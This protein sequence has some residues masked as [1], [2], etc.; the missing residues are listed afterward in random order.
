[1]AEWVMPLNPHFVCGTWKSPEYEW[2][3]P[4]QWERYYP[5]LH[6]VRTTLTTPSSG[7]GWAT[8]KPW[9][10]FAAGTVCFFHPE[11]DT[12][13]NILSDAPDHLKNWLRV[14][15]AREL[16]A[17]IKH[18]STR[19]GHGDWVWLVEAQRSHF[20]LALQDLTYM[21]MIEERLYP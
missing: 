1:M 13:N 14:S 4:A 11:Y 5:N 8:A 2:I 16:E 15:S 20:E 7:S 18:L 9:E 21:R 17:R 19:A 3:K 10:A 12:Q 6:S